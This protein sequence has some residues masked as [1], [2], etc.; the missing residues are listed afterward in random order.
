ML[1]CEINYFMKQSMYANFYEK[2][3]AYLGMSPTLP[4]KIHTKKTEVVREEIER[5]KADTPW[6][7]ER[8]NFNNG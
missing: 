1:W 7:Y 4:S 6:L 8:Y 2:T 3:K 5:R